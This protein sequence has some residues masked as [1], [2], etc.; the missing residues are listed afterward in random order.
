[1]KKNFMEKKFH[2]SIFRSRGI[3]IRIQHGRK[4]LVGSC[5]GK[6]GHLTQNVLAL[7]AILSRANTLGSILKENIH[8]TIH[9]IHRNIRTILAYMG[10]FIK[11]RKSSSIVQ[12]SIHFL[13]GSISKCI[14]KMADMTSV[15][16]MYTPIHCVY[17]RYTSYTRNVL[18]TAF[19][20]R[21]SKKAIFRILK[22]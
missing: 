7:V 13:L 14:N 17:I 19:F 20:Y 16:P 9:Q 15:L 18:K 4:P 8:W 2:Q 1:M 6:I 12:I 10:S 3:E 22:C 21:K 5:P 11:T